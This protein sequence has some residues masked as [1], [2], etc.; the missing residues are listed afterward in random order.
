MMLL[1]SDVAMRPPN[2][3]LPYS[4]RSHGGAVDRR[5]LRCAPTR[6]AVVWFLRTDDS[7]RTAVRTAVP[8]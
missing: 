7:G 3:S 1:P 6:A 2:T 8:S 5:E 4:L